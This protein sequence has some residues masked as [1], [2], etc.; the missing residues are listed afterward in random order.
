MRRHTLRDSALT[1]VLSAGL[2]TMASAPRPA[3]ACGGFFCSAANP[4]NQAAEQII[5]VDNPDNTVTAVIQ[6]MYEGPAERFAWVLPVPG[7][8]D[9]KVSSDQALDALKQA[10]NPTYRLNTVFS[11]GCAFPQ[12][13]SGGGADAGAAPA[14][15][16][17]GPVMVQASGAVGPYLWHVISVDTA[18]E[19]PADAAIM[20]LTDNDYDVGGL[21]ADVLRPYLAERLNLIAFRL[22]EG[23]TSGSIRPV[24]LTYTSALPSI[25]IRPT[26]VA[27]NDDMGVLVWALSDARAIPRNYKALELNEALIDWFNPNNNYNEVVSRAADEAEGHGF[28]TEYAD[29]TR[30]LIDSGQL[31]IF[32]RWQEE[33]WADFSTRRHTDPVQMVT[34]AMQSWGGWDGFDD[35]LR[36]SVMLPQS[37]SF[38]DFKGCLR[39]YLEQPGVM[40]NTTQYLTNL[41]ELVIRP[42]MDTQALIESRPYITRLYT[43][44]SADEM[45]LDPVF[46]FNRDLPTVSNVHVA[47]RV[48]DCNG[49]SPL[50]NG[51]WTVDLPQGVTVRGDMFG[52]W[53]IEID[54][55]PAA[56]KILQFGTTGLGRVIEDRTETVNTM[57][58]GGGTAGSVGTAGSGGSGPGVAGRSGNPQSPRDPVT[59]GDSTDG[60]S[61]ASSGGCSAGGRPAGAL[62][63]LLLL[64]IAALARRRRRIV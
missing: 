40:F 50:G 20:W 45:T 24:M 1:A 41:Y 49:G 44:M 64:A 4:V 9:V 12:A 15:D 53:P 16:A 2:C 27:A 13:A 14:P 35:A 63:P 60:T 28:V 18:H 38:E 34:E 19:D 33:R 32:P 25:P 43:T 5:F 59:G 7:V 36:G 31:N 23:N 58:D 56:L 21:G 46:D 6:I 57:M 54:S 8:P 39:C 61:K 22:Q 42:M 37:L 62:L 17:E 30:T 11:G 3:H 55:M 47:D 52:V 29:R 48:V 51:A 10:T 26:A